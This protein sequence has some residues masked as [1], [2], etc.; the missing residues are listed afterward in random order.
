MS[1]Y[2]NLARFGRLLRKHTAEHLPTYAMSA[3]VLLGGMVLVLG[4]ITY[5]N[6]GRLNEQMQG[7]FF[8]MFLLAAGAFFTSTVLGQY[9]AG[10]QAALALTLPASQLEKLLV[11]W[12]FSLPGFLA[13]FAATFYAA[14][15][16]V[17]RTLGKVPTPLVSLFAEPAYQVVRLYLGLHGVALW[18]SIFFGRLQP[19]KVAFLG[20]GAALLVG[21]ANFHLLNY[22]VDG[23]LGMA[24]PFGA[25]AI[26][27]AGPLALPPAQEAWLAAVP[28][29]LAALL[30]AAAYARLT[31]K[32]L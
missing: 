3:A 26:N 14:D 4:F 17:L 20:F 22:W 12:L 27:G 7:I 23:K 18:G 10:R 30:W 2:F 9:G 1:Q 11:A 29:A 24:I 8:T 25:A 19:V 31:E 15:W 13:V 21:V 5:L 28:L 6:N 32:Q 16:L